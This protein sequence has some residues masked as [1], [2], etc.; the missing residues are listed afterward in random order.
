VLI[1]LFKGRHNITVR[2]LVETDMTI[3]DL[4][5]AEPGASTHLMIRHLAEGL[6]TE[7]SSTYS[8]NHSRAGPSHT[9]QEIRGGLLHLCLNSFLSDETMLSPC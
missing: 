4:N 1:A 8:P 3:A 6:G 7:Y 2:C 5:E 9:L